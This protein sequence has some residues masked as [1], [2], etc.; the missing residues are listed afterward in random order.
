MTLPEEIIE[1]LGILA[2]KVF[3]TEEDH[4]ASWE[5]G[6]REVGSGRRGG[7][8]HGHSYLAHPDEIC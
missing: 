6:D 7:L 2:I 3:A 1:A 8:A 4:V 5:G